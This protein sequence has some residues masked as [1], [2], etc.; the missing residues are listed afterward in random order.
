[1][2]RKT[3]YAQMK[4]RRDT[5]ANWE[6]T[7]PVLLDGEIGIVTDDPNLYKVGNGSSRWN[8]LPFRGFDGTIVHETGDSTTAVMSQAAVSEK[9]T[10]LES[11]VDNIKP[12]V[13]NGDVTNAADEEDITSED[14]LLKLK[15]R[16]ALNG[17]GYVILR[18]NKTFAEQVI[19]PNTIYEIRY[20]F[21]LGGATCEIPNNCSLRFVGGKMRNG[22]ILGKNTIIDAPLMYIFEDITING[23]WN[24]S[25]AYP[26]WFG[27]KGNGINDDRI[28]IQTCLNAF[29]VT[30]LSANNYLLATKSDMDYCI[31]IPKAHILK[32]V[33]DY[34]VSRPSLT[35]NCSPL[36]VVCLS[37][38][39]TIE[40]ISING[41]LSSEGSKK[42]GIKTVGI[43]SMGEWAA[44]LI[45]RNCFVFNCYYGFD[46]IT[47][48]T[49]IEHNACLS[50]YIGFY[51][52]GKGMTTPEGVPQ[53][54][55]TSIYV[56]NNYAN[57]CQSYGYVISGFSYSNIVSNA[58]DACGYDEHLGEFCNVYRLAYLRNTTIQGNGAEACSFAFYIA[59]T[60]NVTVNNCSAWL[61]K[62]DGYTSA[63]LQV[64][65]FGALNGTTI[66]G[67][68][69]STAGGGF[70][71]SELD[72]V[73]ILYKAN[74]DDSCILNEIRLNNNILLPTQIILGSDKYRSL[75]TYNVPRGGVTDARPVLNWA[76]G[77][78]T[79]FYDR[80]IGQLLVWD[81]TWKNA[82]GDPANFK[83]F[84]TTAERPNS[85]AIRVGFTFFDTTLGK[86]IYAKSITGYTITWVDSTGATV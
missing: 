61:K 16:S 9:L 72:S 19:K 12:I 20:D 79:T 42:N 76:I 74:S 25:Q 38:R 28:A 13:I 45:I 31:K 78:G 58:C 57:K 35:A 47:Y 22:G 23:S 40:S 85:N 48:L 29:D 51:I 1:M 26:E 8:S 55:G 83:T 56:A 81:G 67:I 80:T 5:K 37:D 18:K 44:G 75:I 59:S 70:E 63:G 11:E 46:L 30:V 36:C 50:C 69:L 27:A 33:N 66:N 86:P 73:K 14:N 2:A 17:M 41:G 52:H 15:D 24:I 49:Q 7:N 71:D 3:I 34:S 64:L 39:V 10:K 84:G 32:G 62:I 82:Y 53:E 6:S 4:Q 54:R 68:M 21:D 43:G 65:V 60:E 77:W